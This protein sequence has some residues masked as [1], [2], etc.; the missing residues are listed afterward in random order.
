[1]EAPGAPRKAAWQ[2]LFN[3]TPEFENWTS[4]DGLPNGLWVP[5]DKVTRAHMVSYTGDTQCDLYWAKP[6][7][8]EY[9]SKGV[10]MFFTDGETLELAPDDL[11]H[12]RAQQ[13]TLPAPPPSPTFPR[14][15]R[16]NTIMANRVK[17][18]LDQTHAVLR[19]NLDSLSDEQIE[20]LVHLH[21][22]AS[23]DQLLEHLAA[24]DIPVPDIVV[25]PEPTS[26]WDSDDEICEDGELFVEETAVAAL[27]DLA[28]E[29]AQ[30]PIEPAPPATLDPL[31]LPGKPSLATKEAIFPLLIAAAVRCLDPSQDGNRIARALPIACMGSEGKK[32]GKFQSLKKRIAQN[33]P[34]AWFARDTHQFWPIVQT[35]GNHPDTR[36]LV[37]HVIS[38]TVQSTTF[39]M[40]GV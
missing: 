19:A 33:L 34:S 3:A 18:V 29:G 25:I 5:F 35:R 8:Q 10:M 16:L 14:N 1:M 6:V 20:G 24:S 30:L 7:K 9:H 17:S 23:G 38:A 2:P 15:S 37:L 11:A 26:C 22:S 31:A 28:H 27:L 40:W 13:S 4:Y 12:L 21:L 36:E 32:E 39:H